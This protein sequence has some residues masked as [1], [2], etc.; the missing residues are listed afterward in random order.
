MTGFQERAGQFLKALPFFAG[1]PEEEVATLL[2]EGHVRTYPKRKHLFLHQDRAEI[3]Y[4][5]ISGCIKT[6]TETDD[7]EETILR[8]LIAGDTLGQASIFDG[9]IY[10]YSASVA[11]V[12]EVFEIRADI[13]KQRAKACTELSAK[14]MMLMS[15]EIHDMQMEKEHENTMNA[16]QR[17]GCMLLRLAAGMQGKGGAFTLPYDKS[18]A[19][20]NLGMKPE[21][22][23]RALKELKELGVS[24]KG[25][26]VII[27]NFERLAAH[28]CANCSSILGSC[29]GDHRVAAKAAY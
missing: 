11:E 27:D 18:L 28:S 15:D 8:V 24:V 17:V 23:S 14:I 16:S 4:I 2:D 7:G 1:L 3:F 5:V 26:E 13:L 25:S 6:Y 10:P 29:K 9:S 21:T 22:F 12:A 19:A 20:A